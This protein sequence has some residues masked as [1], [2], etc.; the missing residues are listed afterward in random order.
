MI[1]VPSPVLAPVPPLLL[2]GRYRAVV[3]YS[4]GRKVVHPFLD[5]E[6]EGRV[7]I[8]RAFQHALDQCYCGMVV[9]R[10]VS[11]SGRVVWERRAA[12]GL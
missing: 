2:A 8:A 9:G 1:A 11:A 5:T 4:D 12:F 3:T 7:R 10:V 6:E